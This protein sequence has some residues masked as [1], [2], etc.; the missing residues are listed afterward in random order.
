MKSHKSGTIHGSRR[1]TPYA[2]SLAALP[3]LMMFAHSHLP[4][5]A[6]EEEL[7]AAGSS[8]TAVSPAGLS[9]DSDVVRFSRHL[10]DALVLDE[11]PFFPDVTFELH[12]IRHTRHVGRVVRRDRPLSFAERPED[13]V[14]R[15]EIL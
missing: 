6:T 4:S 5:A 12:P 7:Q 2:A 10:L 15:A 9:L 14:D 3:G 11:G 8:Y 1:P 13:Y